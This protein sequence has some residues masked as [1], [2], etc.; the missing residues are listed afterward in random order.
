M[1]PFADSFNEQTSRRSPVCTGIRSSFICGTDPWTCPDQFVDYYY[2]AFDSDRNS[3]S[4]LYRPQSMM[5]WE[6]E[7]F[8]G[9]KI[10]EKLVGLPFNK[11]QHRVDTKDAQPSNESGG[12]MVMVTGALMVGQSST[13][14]TAS[15]DR[16]TNSSTTSHKQ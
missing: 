2:K 8:M 4:A 6:K 15:A 11:I 1:S 10:L 9:E 5:T 3:L 13:P 7:P 16:R 14:N 12:I